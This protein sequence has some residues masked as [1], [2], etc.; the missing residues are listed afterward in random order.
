MALDGKVAASDA[1][2]FV[3]GCAMLGRRLAG[4]AKQGLLPNKET[5]A[6]PNLSLDPTWSPTRGT[7][8]LKAANKRPGEFLFTGAMVQPQHDNAPICAARFPSSSGALVLRSFRCWSL[9]CFLEQPPAECLHLGAVPARCR[10]DDPIGQRRPQAQ[11]ERPDEASGGKVGNNKC[12]DRQS[13]A[14]ARNRGIKHQVRLVETRAPGRV[15]PFDPRCQKPTSPVRQTRD[16][17]AVRVVQ[18]HVIAQVRRIAQR[19][20]SLHEHRT[21]YWKHVRGEQ[22]VIVASAISAGPNLSA[23][24]TPSAWKSAGFPVAISRT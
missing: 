21:A 2:T 20:L 3:T 17:L 12:L 7:K 5:T 24:S 15:D 4:A 6:E 23:R 10:C 14:G 22:E 11:I 19:G 9:T 18:Q 16:D 8:S 13:D 1:A